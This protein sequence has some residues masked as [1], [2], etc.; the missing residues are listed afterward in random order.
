MRPLADQQSESEFVNCDFAA[1][2]NRPECEEQMSF[3]RM[4]VT[5]DTSG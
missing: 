5:R 2:W 3:L 1:R 4:T